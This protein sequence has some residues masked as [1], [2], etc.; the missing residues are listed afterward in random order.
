VELLRRGWRVLALDGQA[1]GIRRLR[2][3]VP[4]DADLETEVV[5][6][7]DARWPEAD[8]VNSSFALPFCPPEHFDDVWQRVR[9]SIVAGGRFSGHLFGDR[10]GWVGTRDMTFHSPTDAKAL[11][12]GLELERFDEVEEDGQTATGN[13]KHWHVFHVVAHRPN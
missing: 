4:D 12:R 6:F 8:L 11:L 13:A 1:E 5:R 7:E 3:R 10:D 9:G 2:A